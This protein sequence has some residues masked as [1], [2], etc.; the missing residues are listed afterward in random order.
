MLGGSRR[1]AKAERVNRTANGRETH[2]NPN[3]MSGTNDKKAGNHNPRLMMRRLGQVQNK[4]HSVKHLAE[5]PQDVKVMRS[6]AELKCG[7]RPE[8]I[9]GKG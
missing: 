6:K 1:A 3:T 9:R 5:A 7:H 8:Q 4:G 2:C